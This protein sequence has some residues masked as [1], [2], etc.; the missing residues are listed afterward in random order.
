MGKYIRASLIKVVKEVGY[1][2]I[3]IVIIDNILNIKKV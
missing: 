1:K 2:N 3:I